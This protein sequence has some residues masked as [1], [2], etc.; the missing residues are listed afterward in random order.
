M[1]TISKQMNEQKELIIKTIDEREDKLLEA[2]D[3]IR[4][5]LSE[6]RA[7]DNHMKSGLLSL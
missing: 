5:T 6:I 4:K 2:D 7:N 1:E 3:E